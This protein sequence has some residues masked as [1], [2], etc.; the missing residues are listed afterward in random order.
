MSVVVVPTGTAN[1][2]SVLAALRR[3]GVDP[4]LAEGPDDVAAAAAVVLPGVGH[5]AAARQ[6][7]VG[8]EAPL[9]ERI[10]ADRP[11]LGICLGLQVLLDGSDEAPGVAGLGVIPGMARRFEAGVRCPHLG[12]TPVAVDG[13]ASFLSDGFACFAH[14]YRLTNPPDGW[15]VA[16]ATHGGPFVAALERGR[17]LACQLHPE[18]SGAWGARVLA[19]WLTRAGEV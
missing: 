18:L 9:I 6:S 13:S 15:T 12:W 2:A 11:T 17:T 8:L 3:G 10:Q 16:M 4:R 19:R 14:S 7:L 5:F 1:L